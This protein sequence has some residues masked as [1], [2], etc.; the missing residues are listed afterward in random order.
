MPPDRRIKLM[1]GLIF[2]GNLEEGLELADTIQNKEDVVAALTQV[3]IT[4]TEKLQDK[5]YA[6]MVFK[7]IISL[8]PQNAGSHFNL[9]LVYEKANDTERAEEEYRRA[10]E[11]LPKYTTARFNLAMMLAA[12]NR[13]EEAEKEYLK[14]IK[15]S[16]NFAPAYYNLAILYMTLGKTDEGEKY[17]DKTVQVDNRFRDLVDDAILSYYSTLGKTKT[18]K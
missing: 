2:D 8:D 7:K 3:G 18:K 10:I 9:A 14:L 5:R 16:P 15:I 13:F 4:F 12:L 6:E 1:V 11:L 17:F